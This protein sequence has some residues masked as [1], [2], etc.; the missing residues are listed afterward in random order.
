MTATTTPPAATTPVRRFRVAGVSFVSGYP[1]NLHRLDQIDQDAKRATHGTAEHLAVILRPNP[2]NPH[3]ANAVE[4]HVPALG[5]HGMVGHLPAVLAA[6][7]APRI[8][9][10]W[11]FAAD[12][13]GVA[14]DPDHPERPGLECRVWV[15]SAP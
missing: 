13:A 11:V 14:L 4:V 3:D 10:G 1:G 15:V 9:Q 7:I 2:A 12:V 5:D 8:A 6:R